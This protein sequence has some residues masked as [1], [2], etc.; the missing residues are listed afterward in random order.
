MD[1]FDVHVLMIEYIVFVEQ[2]ISVLVVCLVEL[3]LHYYVQLIVT[4]LG[5]SFKVDIRCHCIG[6]D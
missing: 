5:E 2:L 1:L 3:L 6:D 4:Q